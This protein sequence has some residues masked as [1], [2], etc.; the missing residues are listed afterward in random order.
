[1]LP[2]HTILLYDFRMTL[3]LNVTLGVTVLTSAGVR[4]KEIE[5]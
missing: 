4:R 5:L 1:M 3:K 2:S